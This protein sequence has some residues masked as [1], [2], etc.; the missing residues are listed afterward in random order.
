M[1]DLRTT[2]MHA[3]AVPG[4]ES[5]DFDLNTGLAPE[6]GRPLRP[7]AILLPVIAR[8]GA[9]DLL[10]TKRSS[11]LA[12]H[13]G[14]V[15]CPG[16]K[17]DA[18]DKTVV[19]AALREARE[20]VGLSPARVDVLGTLPNH[21]TVTGYDVTPIVGLVEGGFD[22]VPE[23]G[24]VDEAFFV[25]M[26]HVTDPTR[27]RIE[28]R[29]WQGITRQYYAVPWGPYYIWGATARILRGLAERLSG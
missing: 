26:S 9:V 1:A 29:R 8:A 17:V 21:K 15:A 10:L 13:P 6:T 20:E 27:F 24:E 5:S 2:L 12:H 28:G 16:G 3:L 18:S 11:A 23:A 14:Q 19:A 22:P 4:A 7:A 25:P